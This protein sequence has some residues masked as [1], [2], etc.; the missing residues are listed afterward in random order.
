MEAETLDD[1]YHERYLREEA[2]KQGLAEAQAKVEAY[3]GRILQARADTT[4]ARAERDALLRMAERFGPC[5]FV[6][7]PEPG[8]AW[9]PE[10]RTC[11]PKKDKRI[12]CLLRWARD[13]AES[14]L[15]QTE[16]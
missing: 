9:S 15:N 5:P 16:A 3:K 6:L 10:C 14:T 1:A 2:I 11:Q 12:A 13:E 4:F 7:F 8:S